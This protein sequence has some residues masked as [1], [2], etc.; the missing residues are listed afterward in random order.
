MS[1]PSSETPDQR[2]L[3]NFKDGVLS[4]R[5]S[6]LLMKDLQLKI[7]DSIQYFRGTNV[8]G[9][10]FFCQ[11]C[12]SVRNRKK[13][14]FLC[15]RGA[16]RHILDD[17]FVTK[18]DV[19]HRVVECPSCLNTFNRAHAVKH[20]T[21]CL[22]MICTACARGSN[23]VNFIELNNDLTLT[24]DCCCLNRYATKADWVLFTNPT[25]RRDQHLIHKVFLPRRLQQAPTLNERRNHPDMVDRNYYELMNCQD[26]CGVTFD[27][28]I[29]TSLVPDESG[30]VNN[31]CGCDHCS[32][33]VLGL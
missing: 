9:N 7:L 5:A 14:K 4:M 19:Q 21:D 11:F 31:A 24:G 1:L 23:R 30:F 26:A 17:Y 18:Y 15:A 33:H 32:G 25:T 8:E 29:K 2:R 20:L 27:D 16:F 13:P 22:H 10:Q 6:E 28:A 3:F 12:E